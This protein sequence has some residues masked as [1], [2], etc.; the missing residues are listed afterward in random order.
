MYFNLVRSSWVESKGYNADTF[1]YDARQLDEQMEEFF[2][3]MSKRE[4]RMELEPDTLLVVTIVL[5]RHLD[6]VDSS[7]PNFEDRETIK[8]GKTFEVSLNT[9]LKAR[10]RRFVAV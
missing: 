1:N 3:E 2:T 8:S 6:E 10:F 4:S 7:V 5:V 9:Q